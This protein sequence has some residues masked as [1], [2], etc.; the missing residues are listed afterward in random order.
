[1]I[2][3]NDIIIKKIFIK[4]ELEN[5]IKNK[6]PEKFKNNKYIGDNIWNECSDIP[7]D[8]TGVG[9]HACACFCCAA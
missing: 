6:K 1:M 8:E 3:L 5:F 7:V 4:K 9:A 2:V